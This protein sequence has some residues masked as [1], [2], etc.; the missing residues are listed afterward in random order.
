MTRWWRA[1]DEAVDDPKL[2]KLPA[3]LFRGWFNI[4]CINSQNGGTLPQIEDI[5]FKL[6]C[7]PVKAEQLLAR[8]AEAGLLD[9]KDGIRAPHNWEKRQFK[10]DNADPTNADRQKRYRD[11]HRNGKSN[12]VISVTR[13]VTITHPETEQRQRQR[14]EPGQEGNGS[15]LKEGSA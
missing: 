3:D 14:K 9:E 12:G 5:A 8:L 11:K 15:C 4:C 2:Q 1:Y 10:T 7:S 6:R 13:G